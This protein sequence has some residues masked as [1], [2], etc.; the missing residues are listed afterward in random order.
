M[1]LPQITKKA[2]LKFIERAKKDTSIELEC[3]VRGDA[4][5]SLNQYQFQALLQY[6]RSTHNTFMFESETL[7]VGFD[8]NHEAYRI[9]IEGTPAIEAFCTSDYPQGKYS[10]V[11]KTW[12]D[13]MGRLQ[14]PEYSLTFNIKYERSIDTDTEDALKIM[15]SFKKPENKS[16]RLKRRF[17]FTSE[18]KLFRLD[19][20][21]VKMATAQTF[22]MSGLLE[23]L[24]KYEIEV[25]YIGNKTQVG[26]KSTAEETYKKYLQF[27]GMCML[28]MNEDDHLMSISEKKA[29][30]EEYKV[31]ANLNAQRFIGPMPVTLERKNMYS[32]DAGFDTIMKDYTV[33]DKA[34]GERH[35]LFIAKNKSVY[36]INNRYNVRSMGCQSKQYAS[37]ILDGEFITR[38]RLNIPL[39]MFAV[40]DAY[41]ANKQNIS[42]LSLTE[43]IKMAQK[44]IDAGFSGDDSFRVQVK[45]FYGLGEEND[46]LAGAKAI[47]DSDEGNMLP[48][49]VDGLV[50]T[51]KLLGVGAVIQGGVPRFERT[52]NKVFKWK[53]PSDNTIDFLIL[54]EQ[55]MFGQDVITQSAEGEYQKM[56]QL[57]VGY[58]G[59]YTERITPM[60][61]LSQDPRI[62]LAGL[63]E[64]SQKPFL[65]TDEIYKN[66]SIVPLPI[67]NGH[68]QCKNKDIILN[69]SVVEF[70]YDV[71][72][73]TWHPYRVRSDKTVG[74][75]YQTAINIWRSIH[76]PVTTSMVKGEIAV[77]RS[78]ADEID[79]DMYYDRQYDRNMSATKPMI[80]FHNDFVKNKFLIGHFKGKVKS[81]F[82]IACGK[83]N[84][85]Y[86]YLRNDI[87]TIIGVDKSVDNIMN[88]R[89]GAYQRLMSEAQKGST[90]LIKKN[91]KILALPFDMSVPI[92]N[93]AISSSDIDPETK[94][95]MNVVWGMKKTTNP[96]L[97]PFQSIVQNRFDLVACQF[98]VHYFFETSATLK[99]LI[100]NIDNVIAPGGYFMGTC[101]DGRVVDK[102]FGSAD[103]IMGKKS[104]RTIWT[105]TKQYDTFDASTPSNNIGKGIEV[106]METINKQI[107]EYLVDF[108]LLEKELAAREI[109]LLNKSEMHDLKITSSSGLFS[110]LF[111]DLEVAPDDRYT[112]SAKQ[113]TPEE[114]E[115]S[116]MNRWFIFRKEPI[117]EEKRAPMPA[118]KKAPEPAPA[119]KKLVYKRKDLSQ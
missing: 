116:F 23:T 108:K 12:V 61:Y 41:F 56:V 28:A 109:R 106:Y 71:E 24:V 119:K 66:I 16:F 55:N 68:I 52:W 62:F 4:N 8:H 118:P 33:T 89:D 34:D 65:P 58:Q 54:I 97:E 95:V 25:E 113:M 112:E 90:S 57:H 20:T 21:I 18:D 40:F 2:L 96:N 105:L 74:N 93:D 88:A 44:I 72:T 5:V 32:I 9:E 6:M 69:K 63:N 26:Q 107:K 110:T 27:V 3:L 94:E 73:R 76:N 14:V 92:D 78:A 85:F 83:G 114:K 80:D 77:K 13:D 59:K 117:V 7:N 45:K 22:A 60:K 17:S 70:S 104:G 98:A 79:D 100:E 51:P 48:Y 99:A 10:L 103:Q 39:K 42:G 87:R 115:Y 31:V 82:D 91:D 50:F 84:D 1:M 11:K 81:V 46:I 86:K 19:M 35:L 29:V 36:L 67:V 37:T 47:L 49:Y 101:L 43:R 38:N 111:A 102:A 64:Y 30:I 15:S 75:D 53:P